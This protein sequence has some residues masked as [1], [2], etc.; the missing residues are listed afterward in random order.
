M[1]MGVLF[2]RLKPGGLPH[3]PHRQY[4]LTFI[5]VY[6]KA[7]IGVDGHP[8]GTQASSLRHIATKSHQNKVIVPE[9]NDIL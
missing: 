1:M 2:I 9:G 5:S 6:T 7:I 4:F 3:P 8:T